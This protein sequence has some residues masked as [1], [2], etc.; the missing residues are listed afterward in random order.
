MI[1]L[2][3][4][5]VISYLHFTRSDYNIMCPN[6]YQI[7]VHGC[8]KVVEQFDVQS[9]LRDFGEWSH[10]ADHE[11]NAPSSC[12]VQFFREIGMFSILFLFFCLFI[13]L[14]QFF[15]FVLFPRSL[16]HFVQAPP[17]SECLETVAPLASYVNPF[18]PKHN[19][20]LTT[21]NRPTSLTTMKKVR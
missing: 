19:Q 7:D 20:A 5:D 21:S 13:S 9:S 16:L 6:G 11:K 17:P 10:E 2:L 15:S 3:W 1:L 18:W 14:F 4:C 12:K 8:G